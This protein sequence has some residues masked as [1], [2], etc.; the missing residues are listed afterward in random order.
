MFKAGFILST[1]A[2]IDAAVHNRSYVAVYQRSTKGKMEPIFEGGVI[3]SH[4]EISV[5]MA[6]GYF[7]KEVCEFR[8]V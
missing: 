8:I 5:T 6:G 3:E 4:C 1:D 2:H 7:L